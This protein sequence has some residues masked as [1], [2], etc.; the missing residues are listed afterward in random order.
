MLGKITPVVIL[1]GASNPGSLHHLVCPDITSLVHMHILPFA[2][3]LPLGLS[4]PPAWRSR[5]PH[6][7]FTS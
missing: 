6:P 5:R 2:I 7:G 1:E 3:C 4:A